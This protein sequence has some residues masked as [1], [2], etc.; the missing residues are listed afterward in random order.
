MEKMSF[1]E[2]SKWAGENIR[3]YLPQKYRNVVPGYQVFTKHTTSYNGMFCRPKGERVASVINLDMFYEKYLDGDPEDE[4]LA[5]MADLVLAEPPNASE[6]TDRLLKYDNVKDHI[7]M[8]VCNLDE[9][10]DRFDNCPVSYVDEFV[11]TYNILFE[12]ADDCFG[13]V[14]IDNDIF[15]SYKIPFEQ[16]CKDAAKSSSKVCPACYESIK[17]IARKTSGYDFPMPECI[18]DML[19]V[20][21][22]YSKSG[23]AVLF[24]PNLLN[25]ISK[26]LGGDFYL[27]PYAELCTLAFSAKYEDSVEEYLNFIRVTYDPSNDGKILSRNIYFYDCKKKKMVC[28]KNAF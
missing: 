13:S 8:R 14:L 10:G 22:K 11:I 3:T 23:S 1:E 28:C 5:T 12:Y 9:A 16:F 18:N 17:D 24:Y 2:F 25:K 20:A 6:V 27:L 19:V 15:E 21:D 26:K 4:I 7:F